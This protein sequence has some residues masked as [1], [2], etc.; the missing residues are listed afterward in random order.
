[1]SA[2]YLSYIVGI[3]GRLTVDLP[4]KKITLS[5]FEAS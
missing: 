3:G 1:M 5:L 2:N 4:P